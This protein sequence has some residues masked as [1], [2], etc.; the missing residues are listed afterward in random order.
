M[1]FAARNKTLCRNLFQLLSFRNHLSQ[2]SFGDWHRLYSA[3]VQTA[4]DT[5]LGLLNMA[6]AL[7]SPAEEP[8]CTTNQ[9]N[10]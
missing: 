2:D 6:V 7:G 3:H 9:E 5:T 1:T 8:G 4:D 10:S